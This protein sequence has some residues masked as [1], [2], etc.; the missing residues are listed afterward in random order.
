MFENTVLRRIFG[1]K[2]DEIIGEWRKRHNEDLNDMYSSPNIILIVTSRGMIWA[3]HVARMRRGD[4][5]TGFCGGSPRIDGR[6]ILRWIF[7]KWDGG[8]GLD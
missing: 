8:H 4:L 1:L 7:Q 5:Y 6:I 3:G 2:R